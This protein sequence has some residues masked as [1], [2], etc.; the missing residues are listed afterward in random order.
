MGFGNI[1]KDF[2]GQLERIFD[3]EEAD[4]EDN[5]AQ[6]VIGEQVSFAARLA[7]IDATHDHLEKNQVD[8]ETRKQFVDVVVIERDTQEF[9]RVEAG[10]L[11][12]GAISKRRGIGSHE[13]WP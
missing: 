5:D 7:I 9:Y 8:R 1:G 2:A 13:S 10:C 3:A 11:S 4:E 6:H 12:H